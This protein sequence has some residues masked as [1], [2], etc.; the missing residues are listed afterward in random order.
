MGSAAQIA[1]TIVI[2]TLVLLLLVGVV[3]LL[4]TTSANRR[5]RHRAELAELH[6][7]RDQELRQVEREAAGHTMSEMGRELHDNV[8]QLL[9]VA[10]VGLLDN[11]DP[12]VQQHPRVHT[13]LEALE[14]AQDAVR[15]LGRS[16]N[17]DHWQRRELIEA[18]EL[19]AVRLERLGKA[20]VLLEINAHPADPPADVKTILFRAFQEVISN[21]LR[22]SGARSITITVDD[23]AGL[24]L[25]ISDDGRGC[26]P[27]TVVQGSGLD[28]IRHRCRLINYTATLV[29]APGEGCAWHFNPDPAHAPHHS[30]GG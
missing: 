3:V 28:N 12:A 24:A 29:S 30:P 23:R 8:G 1:I 18:L 11:L 9:T 14:L 13:A 4:L 5:H 15:R 6:L 21:A 19:E 22:H 7:R 26:D 2:A 16:L 20:R 27:A 10:K 25:R 17:Q